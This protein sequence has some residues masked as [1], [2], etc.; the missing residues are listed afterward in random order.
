MQD[1]DP[2]SRYA[3][4]AE[5]VNLEQ[6]TLKPWRVPLK[7]SDET[8]AAIYTDGCAVVS[9]SCR[10]RFAGTGID[11][12]AVLAATDLPGYTYPVFSTD[13]QSWERLGFPCDLPAPSASAGDVDEDFTMELRSYVYTAVNRMGWESQPSFPSAWV[14]ANTGKPVTVSGLSV[15]DN[16]VTLRIYRA[17]SPLDFGVQQEADNQAAWLKVGEVDAGQGGF[18]DDVLVAG[19]ACVS[20]EY[21]APPNDLRELCSW[22]EGRLAGL[23]GNQFV[24]TER[25]L[26]HAWNRKY[27]VSFYDRP[28]ALRC[29]ERKGYVLTDGRP[30]VLDIQGDCEEGTPPIVVHEIPVPLPIISRQ[31]AAVYMG[32][33]VYAADVGLVALNGIEATIITAE[34]Y[35]KAQWQQLLPHTLRGV[36]HQGYYYGASDNAMIRFRLPDSLFEPPKHNALTTLTLRPQ[37]LHTGADGELYLALNDGTYRWHA[38]DDN[39]PWRWHSKQHD[40][41]SNVRMS[42]WRVNGKGNTSVEH[43]A[44]GAHIQNIEAVSSKPYRLPV[45]H[46]GRT[47]QVRLKGRHEVRAYR[48]ATS[49]RDLGE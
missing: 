32:G 30:V 20:Q 7:I 1:N 28:I 18:S 41:G 40:I 26:P 31:S 25:R 10:T 4:L 49:I 14:R 27:A 3:A 48:L 8:G 33:V 17:Q 15:P 29:T 45:G 13:W 44:N 24:M 23:S 6:G 21:H 46:T 16:A 22:R 42:A 11:C 47:W 36:V 38:G 39:L 9:G 34:H 2:Q 35:S 12:D 43:R 37:A 19:E 5:N